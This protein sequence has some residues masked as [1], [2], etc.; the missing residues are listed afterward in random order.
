M[1]VDVIQR[2]SLAPSRRRFLSWMGLGGAMATLP[3]LSACEPGSPLRV[4]LHD[5]PGYAFMRLALRQGL[6]SGDEVTL[7]ETEGMADSVEAMASGQ[8]DAAALTLD[9]L[10]ALRA[11]GVDAVVVLLFDVSSGGDALLGGPHL[12]SLADLRGARVGVENTALSAVMLDR[13]L[14]AGGLQR[15]EI[16]VAHFTGSAEA[17]WASA[18]LDAVLTYQPAV[19]ALRQRGLRVLFDSRQ[20]PFLI[21]DVLA[22]RRE[23]LGSN[24]ATL[25]RLIRGH[26]AVQRQ[27]REDPLNSNFALASLL[28]VDAQQ[29]HGVF[30]GLNIP[31]ER[32][33]R[34]YLTAPARELNEATQ[35][36]CGILRDERGCDTSALSLPGLFLPDY[37]PEPG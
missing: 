8:V 29:V 24:A 4:V 37:L 22:V 5:W 13:A 25:R 23:A 10:I 19:E 15:A 16:E 20:T 27:W 32:F 3:M 2:A 18:N 30:R 17:A 12:T 6:V 34:Q 7:V 11:Q 28:G 31:D 26:F 36:L 14:A 9:N 1:A 33:N 21:V 35:T